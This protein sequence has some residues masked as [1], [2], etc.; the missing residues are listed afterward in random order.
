MFAVLAAYI[1]GI[2]TI[3]AII[4]CW[5]PTLPAPP[6]RQQTIVD[7]W[8]RLV[9]ASEPLIAR[10]ERRLTRKRLWSWLG[11]LLSAHKT[12]LITIAPA[13]LAVLRTRWSNLGRQLR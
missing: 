10:E 3:L 7:R 12:Q 4:S 8:S 5:W 9:V 13:R 2:A 11:K 1:A 6:S